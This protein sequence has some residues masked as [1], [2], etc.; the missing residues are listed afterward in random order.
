MS[1]GNKIEKQMRYVLVEGIQKELESGTFTST[2]CEPTSFTEEDLYDILELLGRD[3]LL[4]DDGI[5]T[6]WKFDWLEWYREH[7]SPFINVP[8]I[9]S[10]D[11]C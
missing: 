7:G 2:G 9:V 5:D 3:D 4:L 1:N 6:D 8:S 11:I 10:I